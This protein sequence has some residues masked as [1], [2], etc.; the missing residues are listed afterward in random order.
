M[1]HG[2][3][4][5]LE[6]PYQSPA[7]LE[8]VERALDRSRARHEAMGEAAEIERRIAQLSSEEQEVMMGMIA[9]TP[10]KALARHLG[11]SMRTV[12][13]RRNT[14]LQTMGAG[15][16]GELGVLMAK[17]MPPDNGFSRQG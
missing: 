9:G 1:N 16:I 17:R 14:V 13:R 10:I 12:D 6:K 11:I 15:S 5:V 8:A 7:L 2:A 4:T 3:I